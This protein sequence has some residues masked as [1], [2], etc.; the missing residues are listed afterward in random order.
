MRRA[1]FPGSFDPVTLGHINLVCRMANIF[2]EVV[3]AV[4]QNAAK[5]HHFTLEE[6]CALW[7]QALNEHGRPENVR[8]LPC[9]G[10]VASFAKE[11]G[12]TVLVKGIRSE[13]D[14]AYEQQIARVN[15]GICGIETLFLP[16]EPSLAH[17]SSSVAM[18]LYEMGAPV[19]GYL[20]AAVIAALAKA[21]K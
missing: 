14:F 15:F 21:R 12:A 13:A 2:D 8:I 4:S 11:Q 16:A 1:M 10:L 6:R 18:H 7:E 17:I 9:T 20:P 5:K 3:V 19:E